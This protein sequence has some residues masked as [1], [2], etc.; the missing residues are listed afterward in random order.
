MKSRKERNDLSVGWQ[1]ICEVKRMKKWMVALI[2][3]FSFVLSGC[4][5][6]VDT[7]ELFC[8]EE[9]SG[10]RDMFASGIGLMEDGVDRLSDAANVTGSGA[11][12]LSAVERNANAIGFLSAAVVNEKVKTVT[13]DGTLPEDGDAYPLFRRF[14]VAYDAAADNAI[15]SDFISFLSSTSVYDTVKEMGYFTE[16]AEK[17]YQM[18]KPLSGELSVAGSASVFPLMERLAAE[19]MKLQP[20]VKIEIQQNDSSTG[21]SLLSRGVTDVAMSSRNVKD[22]ELEQRHKIVSIAGDAIAVIVHP[23]N[24][25]DDLSTQKL[26]DIFSGKVRNW[27]EIV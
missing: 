19:Y 9:G 20:N 11:V 12:M 18:K 7:I 5:K 23:S 14:L 10:T 25:H 8:R 17:T 1:N 24:L 13:I 2:L 22:G 15:L 6:H 26:A 21:I 4:N 27:Y 16:P 3:L